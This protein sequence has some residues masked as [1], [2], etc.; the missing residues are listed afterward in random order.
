MALVRDPAEPD[1]MRRPPRDP[2]EPLVTWARGAHMLAEGACLAVGVLSAYLWVVFQ[3]GVGPRAH[4]V[5]F[6]ALVLV[7]P[8]QA[9]HCRSEHAVW[10][11]LPVNRLV[12]VA[13]VV[14]IGVQWAAVAWPPL[15]VLLGTASLSIGDW[16]VI[17]VA[18]VWPV[19]LLEAIKL[20]TAG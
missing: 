9:L 13:L 11:R 10:W 6:V 2:R 3:H 1:V 4:T 14:L 12:W 8:L 7:H 15:S 5:A 19:A 18:T 16:L 17:A 20:R